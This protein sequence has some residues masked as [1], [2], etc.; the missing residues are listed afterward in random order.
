[1]QALRA[2]ILLSCIR[3]MYG[4]NQT[5]RIVNLADLLWSLASTLTIFVCCFPSTFSAQSTLDQRDWRNDRLPDTMR[6]QL[7]DSLIREVYWTAQRDTSL[8]LIDQ[9][10]SLALEVSQRDWHLRALENEVALLYHTRYYKETIPKLQD[11]L[12]A[13]EPTGN[14][15][16][17]AKNH[18]RL[19]YCLRKTGQILP[20]L[21]HYERSLKYAEQLG[22]KGRALKA[23]TLNS[24]GSLYSNRTEY[25]K[26]KSFYL[27]SLELHTAID[28]KRGIASNLNNLG[29]LH[30][31]QQDYEQAASYVTRSLEIKEQIKDRRG[32]ANSYGIMGDINKDMGQLDQA[33]A[34]NLKSL[35]I[36]QKLGLTDDIANSYYAL[37][38]I[39][40]ERQDFTSAL[41]Y[42]EQACE[43]A[44]ANE[45]W[46]IQSLCHDCLYQTH[47]ALG[48]YKAALK[49]YEIFSVVQ[50]SLFDEELTREMATLEADFAHE[51]ELALAEA[52][53]TQL[54]NEAR[55]ERLLRWFFLVAALV[56]GILSWLTY[57]VSRLRK[58][59]NQA[60]QKKNEQILA[61]REIIRQQ[62]EELAEA[63]TLKNRFFNNIS[64][65]LRTPLTLIISPLEKLL[66]EKNGTLPAD[67]PSTLRTVKRNA[68]KLLTL[69]EELLELAQLE[70]GIASVQQHTVSI[71]PFLKQ[72]F[73][74]YALLAKEKQLNYQFSFRGN[75]DSNI[76]TDSQRLEKIIDNLLNN[77]L[78]FT[79]ADGEVLLEAQIETEEAPILRLQVK[80]TGPGIAPADLE[81]V[82][83]RYFQA[84]DQ[85][86]FG[87]GIGLSLAQESALLLGG[88]LTAESQIGQGSTFRLEIPVMLLHEKVNTPTHSEAIPLPLDRAMST[89]DGQRILIVEDNKELQLFIQQV[90]GNYNCSAA[91]NGVQAL[92]MLR[93]AAGTK[94]AFQLVVTDLMMPEMDGATL[95]RTIKQEEAFASLR[96]I[97][98]TARHELSEKL[99][100]LR[101]GVDDYLTKPFAIEELQTRVH[102]FLRYPIPEISQNEEEQQEWEPASKWLGDLEQEVKHMLELGQ[103][104]SATSLAS[105]LYLSER[106]L[107]RKIK[108]ATGLTTQQYLQLS[109]LQLARHYLEQ[110][111]CRTV[112]EVATKS[113]FN[114]AGYF[115][116]IFLEY[117]GKRPA[118]YFLS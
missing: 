82:F 50:D 10:K 15:H 65:E 59:R 103:E 5:P 89:A 44:D 88:T 70:A 41:Q 95:I 85:Q 43:I 22:E 26:A 112:A 36:R 17:L 116:K 96:L 23:S 94:E 110:G 8:Q 48:N 58:D 115:S 75:P 67:V 72:I 84:V 104:L 109:K 31:R 16:L 66:L 42:C 62:A 77:A 56:L 11:F 101:I 71:Q 46:E 69:V 25:E 54:A 33:E 91:D 49:H 9:Q 2:L 20:A 118:A 29:L 78:K 113:G 7:L 34:F 13:V 40:F 14:Y 1:M 87:T 81:K 55:Q 53:Q 63:A 79:P 102:N 47:N 74:N 64:H 105:A 60:L 4:F 27:A 68:G 98:L 21:E 97:V 32:L 12:K 28:H 19:A 37:G 93:Q 99:K 6:L 92:E 83:D 38:Q 107:L 117:F 86:G 39:A 57:R 90:L 80:D 51:K 30:Y 73:D 52:E 45:V 108:V 24:M 3:M 106:Q 35:A 76:Q 18:R 100:L 61:D 111:A 114:S